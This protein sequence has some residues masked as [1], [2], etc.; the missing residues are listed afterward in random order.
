MFRRWVL[1]QAILPVVMVVALVACGGSQQ[2][3]VQQPTAPAVQAT[4]VPQPTVA[5]APTNAPTAA[6]RTG[7]KLTILSW[8]AVTTLNPHLATGVKDF[9]GATVML[10]PLARYNERDELVPFLAAEIPTIENGG[11]AADGTS[12]TWKIKPGLKWSDGSDFT[13]DDIIFTWRYCVDEATGCTNKTS[14]DS[15]ASIEPIDATTFKIT[16]K[17][18][19]PNPYISF[20]GSSGM[21]LQQ[22]Q[23]ANCIG[24]AAN[25]SAACQ[26]ANLAPI[27]TNAWKLR[28]FRPGDT[29]IYERNPFYRDADSVFFDTVEIKGGGDAA[30]AARAV[31]TTAEADFALNLQIPK[32]VLEPIL[33]GGN[34]DVIAGGSTGGVERIVINFANPDPA[35]GDKRSEPDQPH[36]FLTDP[37]VRRAI[38]LAID[39]KAIAEQLYG[40]T[41]APTCNLLVVPASVNSP[42]TTCERNVEE[43]KRILDEAGWVLKGSVRE[44]DGV[45]LIV[46]LQTSVNVLRQNTQAIIKSNLAEIGIQVYLKAI[47]PAVFFSGDPGNPDTLNKFYADLQMYTFGP[48]SPD[49]QSYLEGWICAQVSSAANR[50]NGNNVSRYCNPAYDALFEQLK[51]EFD[52]QRRAQLAIQMNDLLVNDIVEIPLINRYTPAVKLKNLVG[53][54]FNTFD[55]SLW[56]IAA[57]RR[58]P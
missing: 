50:W 40:P 19:N 31:C 51:T 20:V 35:L 45:K 29:V 53:P 25:T 24:S 26:A 16:W 15:I 41:G 46:T 44:K 7:G 13:I 43:A 6:P 54:T 12:V 2:P 11:I 58:I 34:C 52:P 1:M 56:N 32:A 36:P 30:S 22:K 55:S 17:E 49:P 48:A 33:A 39:R 28:E 23:F 3:Q 4:D 42:N 8:Q 57:W 9:N 47:D 5:L 14:F 37:A 10:E 18:P 38:A 27:G 21:I